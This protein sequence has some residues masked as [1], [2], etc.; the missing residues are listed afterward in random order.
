MTTTITDLHVQ[1]IHETGMKPPRGKWANDNSSQG[2][3]ASKL[4]YINWLETKLLEEWKG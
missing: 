4:E 1:F 3:K 2:Q